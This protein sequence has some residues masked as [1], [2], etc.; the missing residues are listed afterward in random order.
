MAQGVDMSRTHGRKTL[1]A[2]GGPDFLLQRPSYLFVVFS[3]PPIFSWYAPRDS[4]SQQSQATQEQVSE[5]FM[6]RSASLQTWWR[7]IRAWAAVDQ[8]FCDY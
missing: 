1:E 6:A 5:N 7:T 3:T 8:A 4:V 2:N